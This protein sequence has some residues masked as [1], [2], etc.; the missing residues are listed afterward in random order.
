MKPGTSRKLSLLFKKAGVDEE[1]GA[2]VRSVFGSVED[3]KDAGVMGLVKAGVDI[4][5][6]EKIISELQ[7]VVYYC[8]DCRMVL[9]S[10]YQLE[11]HLGG[12][13]HKNQ[14]ISLM[15]RD[16]N[17]KP[18]GITQCQEELLPTPD[19]PRPRKPRGRRVRDT[20]E[21]HSHPHGCRHS[22]SCL[23]PDCYFQKLI[24]ELHC[25]CTETSTQELINALHHA[26][27]GARIAEAIID[28][29]HCC[30]DEIIPSIVGLVK[31]IEGK[32]GK[33]MCDTM[34]MKL[35]EHLT[36]HMNCCLIDRHDHHDCCH[37][38]YEILEH[39]NARTE[40]RASTCTNLC[41]HL[42]EAR[43]ISDEFLHQQIHRDLGN[44]SPARHQILRACK[45]IQSVSS[46]PRAYYKVLQAIVSQ[47]AFPSYVRKII[48][49][50]VNVY[51]DD[52]L[53]R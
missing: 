30:G 9:N 28:T 53:E 50:A 51:E 31:E 42:A 18:I 49:D 37:E 48:Y 11:V 41:I 1:D 27:G 34:L 3:V 20:T 45:L 39:Q 32:V 52:H 15:K 19:G 13:R 12:L 43:L 6:A 23:Q 33:D 36:S 7:R 47:R 29:L 25:G 21:S 16:R 46:P 8:G 17:Y 5:V 4:D 26:D 10:A 22:E 38:E 14:M 24:H 2:R 40:Y 44:A 35:M